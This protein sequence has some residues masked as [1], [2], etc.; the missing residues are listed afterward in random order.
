[1]TRHDVASPACIG[2]VLEQ[3][4]SFVITLRCQQTNGAGPDSRPKY[5]VTTTSIVGRGLR[6]RFARSKA[7]CQLSVNRDSIDIYSQAAKESGTSRVGAP[8]GVEEVARESVCAE[9]QTLGIRS[10]VMCPP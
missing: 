2:P 8:A 6:V 9:H 7:A 3:T 10:S 4:S 1:M 5:S